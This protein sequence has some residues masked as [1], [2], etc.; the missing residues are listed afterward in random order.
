MKRY[1]YIYPVAKI[2]PDLFRSTPLIWSPL[3]AGGKIPYTGQPSFVVKVAH[4][5][6]LN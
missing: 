6:S 3:T 1:K 4:F 5:S 2:F